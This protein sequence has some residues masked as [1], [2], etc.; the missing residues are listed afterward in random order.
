MSAPEVHFWPPSPQLRQRGPFERLGDQENREVG[1][2][3]AIDGEADRQSDDPLYAAETGSTGGAS[4][5]RSSL[6]VR[7]GFGQSSQLLST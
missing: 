4:I 3:N 2:C 6:L 5:P 7:P 1:A